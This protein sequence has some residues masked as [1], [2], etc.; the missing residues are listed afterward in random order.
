MLDQRQKSS[1]T[2]NKTN[3]NFDEK[4]K[5]AKQLE[6]SRV[7]KKQKQTFLFELERTKKNNA[8]KF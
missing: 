5:R 2:K 7:S 3:R 8:I 6:N 4:K 1:E